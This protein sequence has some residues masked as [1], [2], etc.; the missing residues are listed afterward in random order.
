MQVMI[1]EDS[2][3]VRSMYRT[4]LRNVAT[5]ISEAQDGLEAVELYK[6][7][8]PD[9]VLMDIRM[10]R[11]DGIDATRH[12]MDYD[13]AAVIFIVTEYD[14]PV[15]REQALLAGAQKYILKTNLFELRGE[16][17]ILAR[18]EIDQ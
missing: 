18:A 11:M 7:S 10:P 15:F 13:T 16:L 1:V 14:D 9:V 5:G 12:I 17:E 6:R 4:L 3:Q 2:D 8:R